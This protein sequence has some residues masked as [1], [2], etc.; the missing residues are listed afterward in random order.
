M[1]DVGVPVEAPH[2]DLDLYSD[3]VLFDPYP[4]YAELRELGPVVWMS[5]FG[6]YALARHEQVRSALQDWQTFSSA[7]GVG[8]DPEANKR[9]AG[10]ILTSD[11]PVHD[12]LRKVMNG[13]LSA[14]VLSTI[15]DRLQDQADE[16][17]EA[18]VERGSFDAITELAQRYTEAVIVDLV[19]L[20]EERRLELLPNADAAFNTF[21]P[22]N[23]RFA[24]SMTGLDRLF[25]YVQEV[26]VPGRL[27]PDGKGMEIYD[28]AAAGVVS[29]KACPGLMTSYVWAGMDT[30]VDAIGSAIW[31]FACHPDQWALV[32]DDPSLIPSA[33]NEVLRIESP[34]QIFTRSVTRSID[35]EHVTLPAGARVMVIF[36]SANRDER[37]YPDPDRFDVRRNPTD[38][39]AFGRGIHLC[40]GLNL[41]RLEGH[42]V[43]HAL[44]RRVER[45]DV[46]EERR[47]LNNAVRGLGS[48]RVGVR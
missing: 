30:T 4:A 21:G 24:A 39:V 6:T 15:A 43:L 38:H 8:L 3:N 36:A 35:I 48:L 5:R 13:Q 47:H 2:S 12:S 10:A 23:D 1:Q 17:V 33:F 32:R 22:A 31:L 29:R 14:R 11:P 7:A 19:G 46:I 9:T 40:V 41:A 25:D 37:R 16:L 18:L 34:V 42:A 45:F 26:A 44:A 28:A 20:P 27:L